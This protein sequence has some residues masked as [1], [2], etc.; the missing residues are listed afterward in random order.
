M[1]DASFGSGRTQS[2]LLGEY[3]SLLGDAVLRHRA[4]WAEQSA[5]V[6]AEL[7]NRLK[8][9]FIANMSHELRTPLNSIIGFSRLMMDDEHTQ[10]NPERVAEYSSMINSSAEHLLAIINDILDISKIQSG[11]FVIDRSDVAM[12]EVIRSS[13]AFFAITAQQNGVHLVADV[14]H[15]LPDVVGDKVK[16]KQ[17]ITNL[18]SNGVKFTPNDGTVKVTAKKHRGGGVVVQVTDS[19]VGMS[20]EELEVAMT[21]FGQV[22]GSHTR[23]GEGTGLGLPIAAALIEMHGALF[24]IDSVK[25]QGT[26]VQMVFPLAGGTLSESSE[27]DES[28]TSDDPATAAVTNARAVDTA[29]R[30]ELTR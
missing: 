7:A 27:D 5:R 28:W 8:S 22:D 13:L 25:D 24:S 20:V 11:R 3:A 26:T 15:D 12:E 6:E 10:R 18:V 19:G 21:P 9:E 17:V 23:P 1:F 16:L 2:S 4:H 30:Q 29:D 14:D